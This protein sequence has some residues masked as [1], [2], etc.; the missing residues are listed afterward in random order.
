MIDQ[1]SQIARLQ[2][3]HLP[4]D[5]PQCW[6]NFIKNLAPFFSVDS[7]DKFDPVEIDQ[8]FADEGISKYIFTVGE[9]ADGRRVEFQSLDHLMQFVLKWS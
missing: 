5:I 4:N 1:E 7:F 9:S 3:G 2:L 8:I 6:K